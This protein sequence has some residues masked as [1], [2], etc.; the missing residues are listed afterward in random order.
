MFFGVFLHVF[1]QIH[2]NDFRRS[3]GTLHGISA[4]AGKL[5]ALLG[6]GIFPIISDQGVQYVMLL[7]AVVCLLGALLSYIC[8]RP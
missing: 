4:A 5:G 8:L 7:Q 2:R 1:H 3:R 6:A